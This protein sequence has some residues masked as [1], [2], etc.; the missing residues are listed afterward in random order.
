M[1]D[2]GFFSQISPAAGTG[3]EDSGQLA[4]VYKTAF[5]TFF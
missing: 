1:K 2:I 5:Y 4:Y 3:R